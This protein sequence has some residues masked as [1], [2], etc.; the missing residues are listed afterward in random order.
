MS[1]FSAITVSWPD[2]TMRLG[3]VTGP[4]ASGEERRGKRAVVVTSSTVPHLEP[5]HSHPTVSGTLVNA[6]RIAA[7]RPV[8]RG[9]ASMGATF[10]PR[11]R[12]GG[13]TATV[14][15]SKDVSMNRWFETV[16]PWVNVYGLGFA[17]A[18]DGCFDL[19]WDA[20]RIEPGSAA[21]R[22]A[23]TVRKTRRYPNL[24]N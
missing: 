22:V 7:R 9:D 18:G 20:M 12:F 10:G 21:A 6:V 16:K 23:I 13:P 17:S 15:R 5:V 19:G 11:H 2:E 4:R 3:I 1:P 8:C 24:L 14:D